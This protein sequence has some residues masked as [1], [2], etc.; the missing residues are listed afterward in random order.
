ME[1][2]QRGRAKGAGLKKISQGAAPAGTEIDR[3]GTTKSFEPKRLDR[4]FLDTKFNQQ[5]W[6]NSSE[7]KPKELV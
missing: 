4:E 6:N 1:Q 7:E 3:I 2:F 5:Q